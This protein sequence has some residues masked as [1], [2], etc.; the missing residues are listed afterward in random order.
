[1]RLLC[2]LGLL[3]PA[4]AFAGGPGVGQ[5]EQLRAAMKALFPSATAIKPEHLFLSAKQRK[6]LGQRAAAPEPDA[7]VSPFVVRRGAEVLGY[8]F[9][10]E[11]TVRSMP[12]TLL[13]ALSGAGVV[14]DVRVLSF[15]EPRE[16][17]PRRGWLEQFRDR[18]GAAAVQARVDGLS[19]ATL[20]A[21]FT[22]AR[23]RRALVL[24]QQLGKKS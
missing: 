5:V 17:L 12:A 11:G 4:L 13:V 6:E 3:I 16:Y 23:V 22:A 15:H 20:S 19:G 7:L 14:L 2:T 8:A 10:E 21:D 1:M 24:F 18:S 9:L